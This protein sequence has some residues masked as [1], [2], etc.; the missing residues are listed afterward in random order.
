M[1]KIMN[2]MFDL[3]FRLWDMFLPM[4]Y[5]D[6]SKGQRLNDEGR[7]E[8]IELVFIGEAEYSRIL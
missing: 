7:L 4:Y 5:G 8:Q 6:D 3:N 1:L 2:A